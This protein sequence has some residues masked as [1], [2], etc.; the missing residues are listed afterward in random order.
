MQKCPE[1]DLIL[2]RG[3][4]PECGWTRRKGR[5]LEE[6]KPPTLEQWMD[7]CQWISPF[8]R[9]LLRA[10]RD[11]WIGTEDRNHWKWCTWHSNCLALHYHG[12]DFEEF[13]RWVQ[14]LSVSSWFRKYKSQGIFALCQGNLVQLEWEAG[15]E[16]TDI[17]PGRMLPP[18]ENQ[19]MVREI[20]D[21]LAAQMAVRD[22]EVPF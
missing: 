2:T 6:N 5:V 9:C 13:D 16:P 12:N 18:H 8:G 4:C 10:T 14:G 19:R 17:S 15:Y 22:E 7:Q 21:K 1:C 11:A 3:K 20:V